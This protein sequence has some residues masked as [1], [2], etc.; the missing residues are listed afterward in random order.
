MEKSPKPETKKT[1]SGSAASR[2]AAKSSRTKV[3]QKNPKKS[4]GTIFFDK[5]PV[6]FDK[7]LS[8]QRRF[9]SITSAQWKEY[10]MDLKCAVCGVSGGK[11][12]CN[13]ADLE[14]DI[15]NVQA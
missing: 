6:I 5:N 2:T 9:E 10:V 1:K 3:S 13:P 14:G 15:E 4:T 8:E 12:N 11:C 7:R